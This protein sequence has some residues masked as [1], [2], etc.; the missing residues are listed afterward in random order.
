MYVWRP[1]VPS[2]SLWNLAALL[3]HLSD[4]IVGDLPKEDE[5]IRISGY[6]GDQD[7]DDDDDD[8]DD[9]DGYVIMFLC[10]LGW[11]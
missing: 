1:S 2:W 8:D 11:G 7:E 6:Q 5:N 10:L 4:E 3:Q 9:D